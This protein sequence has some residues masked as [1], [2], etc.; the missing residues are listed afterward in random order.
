MAKRKRRAS[1]EGAV[2]Y[3]KDEKRWVG[4]FFDDDGKR[5]YRSG[6]TQ[7]EVLAKL[8]KAKQEQREGTLITGPQQTIHQYLE[9][10]LE[11][12]CKPPALRLSTYV[13]YSKLIHSY[14]MPEL[15]QIRLQKLTPQR[16]QAF[17]RKRSEKLAPKTVHSIHGVLH[18]AL[19]DAVRWNLLA[20][21]VC[22]LVKPPKIVKPEIH[23]L[24]MEQARTLLETARGQ[25]LEDLIIVALTTGVRRGEILGLKWIDVDFENSSL[26]IRRTL[27][28][29]A[30]Y[31][32]YIETEPKT[33]TGRRKITLPNFVVKALLH[34][35]AQ[36]LEM[37]L[38]V[39]EKWEDLGYVFTGL[40]GGRLNPRYLNKLFDRLLKEAN[41]PHMR[42]HDLRHSAATLLL[43]MGVHPKVVQEILGHSNIGMTMDTYSHVLPSM[44][45]EAMEKW[46]DEFWQK[47]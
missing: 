15:G 41:L 8:Q 1:G 26:Q 12:V 42:F 24:T 17:Y 37:R 7:E 10:W 30:K 44:H 32:G 43:S 16:V 29:I 45:K 25:R 19:D 3:R 39:G 34:P 13:K 47:G 33:A 11:N 2:Y 4:S 46:D 20:R 21:N 36:Q 28:Y 22:D 31:G 27:D 5:R 18:K 35:R 38:Q 23:P 14:I 6:K 40:H 9:Y